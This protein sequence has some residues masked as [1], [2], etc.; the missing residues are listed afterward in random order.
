MSGRKKF[1]ITSKSLDHGKWYQELL[2][3]SGM[4]DYTDVSGCY[5]LKP[6][7]YAIWEKLKSFLNAQ[8]VIRGVDNAYFPM[9][10][11]ETN[12]QREADHLEDF[13]PEVAWISTDG[14]S[15]NSNESTNE[16]NDEMNNKKKRERF[17]IRPTSET[18]IYPHFSNWM[19]ET[20][21]YPKINQWCNI[22]RWETKDC[23]PFIRSREFLWQE[24]HT[25]HPDRQSAVDEMWD[26]LNLYRTT[27][28]KLLAVPVIPGHKTKSETFPGADYTSTIEG[29]LPDSGRAIQAATSHYLGLNFSKI[30]DIRGGN[31]E[32]AHQNSWGFTTRSIGI[33]VMTHSDDKGLVLPPRIAPIQVVMIACGMTKDTPDSIKNDVN[34]TLIEIQKKIREINVVRCLYDNTP[35]ETP[36]MKFNKWEIKGVPIRLELGP[37][38]LQNDEISIVRRDTLERST[39]S[40]SGLLDNPGI[41]LNKLNEVHDDMLGRAEDRV[42]NSIVLID[43][44]ISNKD[45]E[46]FTTFV[47]ALQDQKL[48]LIRTPSANETDNKIDPVNE[49]EVFLKQSCLESG[50]KSTKSLCYPTADALRTYGFDDLIDNGHKYL[51]YGRS[52]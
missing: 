47:S 16:M 32:L 6:W 50:I 48:C 15:A 8:I 35:N 13:A 46:A 1:E 5:V 45:S 3:R 31:G 19:K 2:L 37:R 26:I 21:Q 39:M 28:E 51:L 42:R 38:D 30:F 24:G 10:V 17:A 33:A 36:G 14:D 49:L 43:E 12:L 27:Y 4:I 44:I 23:T 29:F 9:L 41:I 7:A 34:S 52:Y 20:G 40:L 22:L 11:S 18:I 25:C